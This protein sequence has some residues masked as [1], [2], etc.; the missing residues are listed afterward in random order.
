MDSIFVR[1]WERYG[2]NESIFHPYALILTIIMGLALLFL[3]RR[4]AIVPFIVV[5]CLVTSLQRIVISGLDF[6]MLRLL[7]VFGIIRILYRGEYVDLKLNKIDRFLIFFVLANV[8]LFT[9]RHGTAS[10]LVNRLGVGFDII[11]LYFIPRILFRD[12]DDIKVAIKSILILSIP[13]AIAMISEQ[14]TGKNFFPLTML[15]HGLI[16]RGDSPRSQAA[17]SHPIHAGTF[18]AVTF[19][20]YYGYWRVS[21]K[22]LSLL[23]LSMLTFLTIVYTSRSS[24]PVI[25]LVAVIF[26][27]GMWRYRRYVSFLRYAALGMLVVLHIIMNAP[28]WALIFRV[29]IISGSHGWHRFSL[30]NQA[31]VNFKDWALFGSNNMAYWGYALQDVTNQ[32]IRMGVDGGALT[33]LFFILTM[34]FAFRKVGQV[35]SEENSSFEHQFMAWAL[36][37]ALFGHVVSFLAVSYFGQIVLYFYMTLAAISSYPGS[38]ESALPSG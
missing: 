20:L 2:F 3:H 30:I 29:P 27:L 28:V 23:M 16:F 38:Q 18:G 34:W 26:A 25:T 1:E 24:G 7:V 21:G 17:F 14:M 4:Y 9:I 8:I 31:I 19:A 32:Y 22:R 5:T 35:T 11:G 12:I 37:A 15:D 36:G 13:M 10:A 33:L 6:N